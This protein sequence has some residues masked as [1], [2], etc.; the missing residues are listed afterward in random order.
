MPEKFW[1]AKP[2]KV[3]WTHFAAA[4]I[5]LLTACSTQ[6]HQ[7]P[8]A[9]ESSPRPISTAMG[10]TPQEKSTPRMNTNPYAFCERDY[11]SDDITLP[12][13][14]SIR[15]PQGYRAQYLVAPSGINVPTDALV[16]PNGDILVASSRSGTVYKIDEKGKISNFAMV[17][18]YSMDIDQKGEVFGYFF[19]NG[20]VFRVDPNGT[21]KLIAK[22]PITACESTMAVAPDGILYIG[23][24]HCGTKEDLSGI[25]SIP[26]GGGEPSLL[27]KTRLNEMQSLTVDKYGNLYAMFGQLLALVDRQTG[28]KQKINLIPDWPSFHGLAADGEGVFYISTGDFG[29]RGILFKVTDNQVIRFAEFKNNGL[30]GLAL[31]ASGEVIGVQRSVGGRSED[32]SQWGNRPHN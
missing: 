12:Q 9:V 27:L 29:E 7:A 21:G 28:T 18:V 16:L 32:Q 22:V 4:L 26:A 5:F 14:P 15:V 24:N 11:A 13:A 8:A 6:P 3:R 2:G 20:E 25:Y 30:E 1:D 23:L 19:P 17:S 31:T 10:Q